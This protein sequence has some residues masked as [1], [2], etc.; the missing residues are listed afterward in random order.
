[1]KIGL[2]DPKI[3]VFRYPRNVLFGLPDFPNFS[4]QIRSRFQHG[5]ARVPT[6]RTNFRT[7]CLSHVLKSLHLA[8]RL[9]KM[10]SHRRRKHLHGLDDTVRVD[11]KSTADVNTGGFIIDTVYFPEMSRPVGDH[12]EGNASVHHLGEFFFIPDFVGKRTVN[13]CRKYLNAQFFQF[14]VS[15]SDR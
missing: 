1:V 11:N 6:G 7:L 2:G 10:S 12:G 4:D 9:I 14:F 13:A 5:I 8:D 15:I 3:Q